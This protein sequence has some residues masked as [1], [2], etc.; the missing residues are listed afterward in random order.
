MQKDGTP[1]PALTE[2]QQGQQAVELPKTD[3]SLPSQAN[4]YYI[5]LDDGWTE[6]KLIGCNDSLISVPVVLD[7]LFTSR[8]EVL[9]YVYKLQLWAKGQPENLATTLTP[10]LQVANISVTDGKAAVALSGTLL[11]WGTCDVPRV[12]EQLTAVGTQFPEITEVKITI[13]GTSLDDYLS[14]K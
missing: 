3:M 12:Q 11:L 1:S 8:E 2:Q 9:T 14:S 13:N 5:K 6:G 4:M 7:T 10:E